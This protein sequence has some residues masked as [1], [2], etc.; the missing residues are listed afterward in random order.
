MAYL[1]A[2]EQPL[3]QVPEGAEL[4]VQDA[5]P[6]PALAQQP[7]PLQNFEVPRPAPYIAEDAAEGVASLNEYNRGAINARLDK[8]GAG[9]TI[10]RLDGSYASN[11]AAV[12][13]AIAAS[14]L[15]LTDL[16]RSTGTYYL[17]MQK[18]VPAEERGW[19]ASLW[20]D[21]EII[22]ETYLLKMNRARNGVYLSLLTDADTLADESL[23]LDVL[24]QI[25]S[26]LEQ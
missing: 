6:I 10:L 16:N 4:A 5:Y 1:Q 14:D 23:T 24:K 26:K 9:S 8:D 20:G 11:W 15:H 3:I 21:D 2:E 25:E 17:A 18:V 7:E 22:T 19:W 13:D 12:T